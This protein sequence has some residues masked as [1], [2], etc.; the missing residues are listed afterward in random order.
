MATLK[1]WYD[2]GPGAGFVVT[3]PAQADKLLKRMVSESAS[4]KV[5]LMAQIA[6]KGEG[7]DEGTWSSLLQFGVREAKRGF[8]GWAGG[9][10]NERGVISDNGATSPTD[11]L[12]DYQLHERP[13]PSN[14]EVPLATVR[15]AVLD[16][17][18]TGGARPDGVS[19]REV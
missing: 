10:R 15:Q 18:S 11:V 6:L 9:G 3:T 19:W 8:V 17:V 14:A 5:G 16:Y 2:P 12:Y 13:V 7:D 1:A 4:E